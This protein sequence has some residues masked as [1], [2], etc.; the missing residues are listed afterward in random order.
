MFWFWSVHPFSNC[1][2]KL[3]Q[4]PRWSQ[5]L[6]NRFLQLNWK[7]AWERVDADSFTD[8]LKYACSSCPNI[9]QELQKASASETFESCL[10]GVKPR[11][12]LLA[13]CWPDDGMQ[14]RPAWTHLSFSWLRFTTAASA[15]SWGAQREN[16]QI[17]ARSVLLPPGWP[18]LKPSVVFSSMTKQNP[19]RRW[20]TPLLTPFAASLP[21]SAYLICLIYSR[22]HTCVTQSAESGA[23]VYICSSS[24][25]FSCSVSKIY[26]NR[27]KDECFL[28]T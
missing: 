25:C 21:F 1:W 20:E 2:L 17:L 22:Q 23:E 15:V 24:F 9:F 16:M 8:S 19:G 5:V 27:R 12:Q 13:L 4:V 7:S 28:L 10:R 6:Q 18:S 11:C 26:T 3:R 14:I